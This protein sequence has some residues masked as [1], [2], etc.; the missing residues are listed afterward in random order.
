M[1]VKLIQWEKD[2]ED[3]NVWHGRRRTTTAWQYIKQLISRT[4]Y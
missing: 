4:Y 1:K 3:M 2:H